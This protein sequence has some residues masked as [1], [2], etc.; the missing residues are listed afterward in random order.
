MNREICQSA[1]SNDD[2]KKEESRTALPGLEPGERTLEVDS[3]GSNSGNYDSRWVRDPGVLRPG[4]WL[5]CR[6]PGPGIA[7]AITALV[8]FL[9]T[10]GTILLM[11]KGPH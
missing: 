8:I 4:R 7:Y 5:Q 9:G 6:I 10:P 2:Q 1:W 3:P 11:E